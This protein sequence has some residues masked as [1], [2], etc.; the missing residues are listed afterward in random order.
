MQTSIE[1]LVAAVRAIA[2]PDVMSVEELARHLGLS[3][4]IVSDLIRE[5]AIPAKKI[6][7]EWFISREALLQ[8]LSC[9]S[10]AREEVDR[11]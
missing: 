9:S 3:P 6:G 7:S 11:G 2:L 4:S 8:Y 1:S 10:L 5:G